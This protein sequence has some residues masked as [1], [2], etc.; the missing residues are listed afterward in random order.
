MT[1]ALATYGASAARKTPE[2]LL[3]AATAEIES[4]RAEIADL[5]GIAGVPCWVGEFSNIS[6]GISVFV[7]PSV[8]GFGEFK[9]QAFLTKPS[10][11]FIEYRTVPE[12]FEHTEMFKTLEIIKKP[13]SH[14]GDAIAVV[15]RL[16]E[17]A[18]KEHVELAGK[19][20]GVKFRLLFGGYCIEYSPTGLLSRLLKA[21]NP[22]YCK[23]EEDEDDP[24]ED[25]G[26][27]DYTNDQIRE[28][29]LALANTMKIGV[30]RNIDQRLS[31]ADEYLKATGIKM[32]PSDISS[33]AGVANDLYEIKVLPELAKKL[34]SDGKKAK[35]IAEE[36]GCSISK[37][38]KMLAAI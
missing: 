25:D 14:G 22:E 24:D 35:V 2:E 21:D 16:R 32:R 28:Y 29:A 23:Y 20:A 26:F 1:E 31:I 37:V 8:T 7:V 4:R 5:C 18:E 6:N 17:S 11:V 27:P 15:S 38:R 36:L 3:S 10:S 34:E 9:D 33:V 13:L 19:V 30:G 12:R